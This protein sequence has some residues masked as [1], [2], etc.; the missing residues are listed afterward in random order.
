MSHQKQIALAALALFITSNTALAA[1]RPDAH[2]PIGV[3]ADHTHSAGEV[4]FSYRYMHMN[5]GGNLMGDHSISPDTIATTIPNRFFGMPG[6][7]PSLRIVPRNM[8]MDM[9][10]FGAMY[11]PAD[12]VTLMAMTSYLSRDMTMRTYQGGMGTAVLGNSKTQIDGFGDISLAGIFPLIKRSDFELNI[13][14]GISAPTGTTTKTAQMLTPMNMKMTMRVPYAM[15]LGSGT[16]DLLPGI[17]VKG[18]DGAIGWGLQYQ[19]TIRTGTNSAQ[20]RLG[21]SHLMTGWVS[22]SWAPWISTSARIA[23]RDSARI[24]GIDA[25][26]MGPTQAAD[27]ANY[28]GQRI[29]AYLGAN[30]IVPDGPLENY[31]LGVEIGAPLY[32]N[33]HGVQMKSKWQMTIGLQKAF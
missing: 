7:P 8:D 32:Q 12:W 20:Y 4:M 2:A 22:Y 10:M 17:T 6:Q 13:R 31:R 29:D 11:A 9:H 24:H 30:F 14:A 27:P 18:H 15:Q 25:N 3:M 33:V 1:D 23:A 19:A 16:W 5:M 26:I 21:D 28:G